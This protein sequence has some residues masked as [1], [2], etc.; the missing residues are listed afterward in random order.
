M[1]FPNAN[2]IGCVKSQSAAYWALVR[3]EFPD[4]FARRMDQEKRFG[5]KLTKLPGRGDERF[6]LDQIPDD[7]PTRGADS[8]ACD[9]LCHIA[10]EDI[11]NG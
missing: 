3:K 4:V 8:P 2:C 9:F 11:E 10:A 5:A 7:M 6:T 1:G